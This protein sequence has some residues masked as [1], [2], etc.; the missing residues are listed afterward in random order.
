MRKRILILALAMI[1]LLVGCART[2]TDIPQSTPENTTQAAG[3]T[4]AATTEANHETGEPSEPET[5]VPATEAPEQPQQTEAPVY[6][7]SYVRSYLD[8]VDAQSDSILTSL[9]QEELNQ[10]EMNAKAYE[11]YVLWDDAL[12]LLWDEMEK[13]LPE[14]SFEKLLDEQIAWI[15]DKEAAVEEIGKDFE[16][17]SLYPLI[18]NTEAASITEERVHQLYDILAAVSNK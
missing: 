4:T 1:I 2:G 3:T 9:T 8:S 6:D 14:E 10:S 12:N 18:T 11:L 17:G 16:G 5:T 13:A 7:I 15:E